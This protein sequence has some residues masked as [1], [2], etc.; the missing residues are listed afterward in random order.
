[1]ANKKRTFQS[2]RKHTRLDFS[3]LVITCELVCTT[4]D[5]PTAQTANTALGQYEPDRSVTPTIIRPQTTVNDPDGIYTSGI[6]NHNLASDQH[7]WFVN[8]TPIAKVWKEG[9]DYTII[10][11][12][13]DDNGSLK[14]MRN[15]VPGEVATLA[16]QGMFNDFR[17][18]TNYVVNGSGM[19]LTTTDKGGNKMACSVD[20]EQ[21]AYDP[22]KD[23]LALYEYLVAEGI[24]KAGQR[25]KFVNGKSY[26]RTVTI[27]LTQGTSTITELPKGMTMRLVERGKNTA[28]AAG[29]LEHPEIKS[30]AFPKIGFDMRFTWQQEFEVQFVNASGKVETSAGISLIRD[31][32]YLTQHDV[33]RGNDIVPGQQRYYNYGIFAAGDQ[34]IQYPELYYDIQWWTQARV[35]DPSTKAYKYAERIERQAG[36]SM[37]CSVESLGIGFEKNLCWFD[38]SMDIEEREPA[39]VLTAADAGTVLTDDKGNVLIF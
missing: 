27:T 16:Y 35:Y 30:V 14:I 1:M 12:S 39:A 20:C 33:A 13:S 10:K 7:A 5:S 18:G 38:V 6:N 11:D 9:T 4:A 25:D 29:T 22:L 28:L 34:P 3:P 32:S 21:L 8:G 23:E 17:T 19:A 15:I 26:E 37:E 36:A 24:E 2:E 31:M